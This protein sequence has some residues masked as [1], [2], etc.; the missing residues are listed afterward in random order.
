MANTGLFLPRTLQFLRD[1]EGQHFLPL[2][3][4]SLAVS[5]TDLGKSKLFLDKWCWG[6]SKSQLWILS[7]FRIIPTLAFIRTVLTN[8]VNL[9]R[10][11]EENS[12]SYCNLCSGQEFQVSVH[13]IGSKKEVICFITT[14][15]R[16]EVRAGTHVWLHYYIFFPRSKSLQPI[17]TICICL[18]TSSFRLHG[19]KV[20]QTLAQTAL[21]DPLEAM[22]SMFL[23]KQTRIV[24]VSY[25]VLFSE[26]YFILIVCASLHAHMHAYARTHIHIYIL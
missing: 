3:I 8:R 19:C 15:L 20:K 6:L 21:Q 24:R 17:T 7:H 16:V 25:T 9:K 2:V 23:K 14:C 13:L 10:R 5:Q 18:R 26:T 12:L 11:R 22:I 1:I 4:F